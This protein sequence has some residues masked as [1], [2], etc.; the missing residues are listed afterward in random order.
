[1]HAGLERIASTHLADVRAGFPGIPR[2]V[3]ACN[4]DFLLPENG[5]DR[6]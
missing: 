5:F 6:A 2:R 1:M 4:L 3:S